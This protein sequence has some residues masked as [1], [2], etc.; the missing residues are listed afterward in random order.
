[1]VRV[2]LS[3]IHRVRKRLANGTVTEYHYAW[4]G[5]PKIWDKKAPFKVGSVDYVEA[6]RRAHDIRQDTKG[7][8]QSVIDEFLASQEFLRLG[9]RTRTDHRKNLI[10]ANGI[11]KEFGKAPISG[12]PPRG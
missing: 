7:S 2:L 4:R 9:E 5:G 3:H 12:N 1:M 6:Y 10:A 11:E 8:F